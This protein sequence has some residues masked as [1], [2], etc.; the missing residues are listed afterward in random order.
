MNDVKRGKEDTNIRKKLI[1]L[2]K[3]FHF[4]KAINNEYNFVIC[5]NIYT[6]AKIFL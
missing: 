2:G 5:R 3:G 1:S 4:P 6:F